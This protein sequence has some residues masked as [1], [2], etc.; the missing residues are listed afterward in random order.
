MPLVCRRLLHL[1]DDACKQAAKEKRA[2]ARLRFCGTRSC[3]LL[4]LKDY[5]IMVYPDQELH[6]IPIM[7]PF[8]DPFTHNSRSMLFDSARSDAKLVDI[9]QNVFT[10]PHIYFFNRFSAELELYLKPETNPGTTFAHQFKGTALNELHGKTLVY[11]DWNQDILG[12]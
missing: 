9:N 1:A 7:L 3:R 12:R 5:A 8:C 4:M 10:K 11:S 6:F 2:A